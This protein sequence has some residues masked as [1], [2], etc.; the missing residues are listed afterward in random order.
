MTRRDEK[1]LYPNQQ[2][3]IRKLRAK[4]DGDKE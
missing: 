2:E 4:I 1:K 3:G